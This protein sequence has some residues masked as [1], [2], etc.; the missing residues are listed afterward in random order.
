MRDH[1]IGDDFTELARTQSFCAR[2]LPQESACLHCHLEN[3]HFQSSLT[4]T[5]VCI[6]ALDSS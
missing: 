2:N 3:K 6:K 4:V 5:T 1:G